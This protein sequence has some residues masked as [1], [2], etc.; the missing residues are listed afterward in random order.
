MHQDRVRVHADVGL[1]PKY[2]L[3]P[4]LVY[5]ISGSRSALLSSS[6]RR[7]GWHPPHK[8]GSPMRLELEGFNVT[9]RIRFRT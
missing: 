6:A 9:N 8:L 5:F 2:Q 7:S 1:H 3:F 4:F